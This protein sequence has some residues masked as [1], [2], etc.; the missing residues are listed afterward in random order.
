MV[1]RVTTVAFVG[2][3]ARRVDVQVQ[4]APGLPNFFIVGLPD[5]AVA[6][7]RERV[8]AALTAVG[9][10]LPPKRI[11]VNLA[12]ADLPKE[13]SHY[14][15]PIAVGLM[16]VIGALPADALAGWSVLGELALDGRITPVNGVLPA[17]IGANSMDLGL[18]CPAECG[19]EA[20]WASPAMELLA[21]ADLIQI[22]NHFKG[23]QVLSRPKPAVR[24]VE[25]IRLDLAEIRGQETAKRA[26]EIAAAG[27]HNLLLIGP[28]GA[29]KSMLAQRLSGILPRLSPAELLEISMIQSI[30]GVL[31]GGRLSAERPFRAPH[32]SASMAAMVG[33]GPR[34]RPGEVS[35][36]HNGVLFLDELPEFTPQVLDSL[37][38]PLESG[39]TVIARAM[40]RVTYPSRFQLIAAMNPCRCGMAGE[41]G[42]SCRRGPRCAADYQARISGPLLDRIDIR[43][44]VPAVTAADLILPPPAEGSAEVA[45]RVAAARQV[46]T[47]RYAALGL[48][49][50]RC[51]AE[52]PASRLEEVARPDAS[53]MALLRDASDTLGLSARGFHRVLRVARTLADLDGADA[54]GRIHIGEAV[55]MRAAGSGL[56][57]AA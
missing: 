29:G 26:L 22:A 38:Q 33:G 40:H 21:P 14:D 16:A 50:V 47:E 4:I 10:S 32:H 6:E 2:I 49:G 28:P 25:G 46:Q 30:A 13:G 17:A 15:L 56:L 54:V 44:E 51:N 1:A 27:S 18:I 52:C 53:G 8:R 20:A 45:E 24:Q 57:A 34:A 37:R 23:T 12:P 48:D 35:L 36:A 3:E 31:S 9:L 42:H 41:P 19:P 43:L 5:K 55:S 11:T 7:S 39:E